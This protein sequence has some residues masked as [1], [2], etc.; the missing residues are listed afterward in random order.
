[1]HVDS[2]ML[3]RSKFFLIFFSFFILA[4]AQG[5]QC[6][7]QGSLAD[8]FSDPPREYRPRV[9]WHWMNGNITREGVRKDIEWMDRAGVV[10][11]HCF[12]A[13]FDVPR[14]VE[15]RLPYMTPE[16]KD[17][18][19]YA[20]DLADSLDMEVSIAS[21][22][23]WSLTGGPWVSKEDAMKKLVWSET[24]VQGGK[25]LKL[26]LEEPSPIC[27]PYLNC[28]RYR[29]DPH[30]YDFYRDVAVV[31]VRLA[32]GDLSMDEM[33]ARL[34]TSD[35]TAP[36]DLTDGIYDNTH[37]VG[38]GPEGFAWVLVEFDRPR[39]VRAY[40]A[41]V[42]AVD[43][44]NYARRLE[45]SDD[46]VHFR[47]VIPRAPETKTTVN[48]YDIPPTT[49]KYFRFCSN[50]P[51]K[52]LNYSELALYGV[53]KVNCATE[54]AGFFTS[55][56]TRDFY[57]T[58][59]TPDAAPDVIDLTSRVSQGVLDWKAPSGRWRI[60]RFGYS[61]TGKQNG[62]ASP[63][64]TGLEVDKY[65][66]DAVARY[67]RQYFKLYDDASG[68]RL[69]SLISHLMIDSY[70][71]QCQTWT[72]SMPEQFEARRGYSLIPWLPAVAGEVLGSAARTERFLYDWRRTMEEMM[73]EGH[74]DSVDPILAEY[75][76]KRHTEAQEYSRVYTADGMDVRRHADIPMA[77]FW[78]REPYASYECEEADMREAASVAH[79][80][81]QN[82]CASE[83][84]TTNGN[85]F[86]CYDRQ[87]AW[88]M[89]PGLL[90]PAADA[91][92]ASGLTRFIIHS[93]I[94]Q[95][96]DDKVPGLT[97]N[98]FGMAFN[99]HN[100]WASEARPW[101]DYLSRST[102]LLSQGRFA[103]DVAYY[104][105]ETTNAVA[106]FHDE[107]PPVPFG[108]AYDF[109]NKTLVTD[110]L[111][112]EGPY[113][114]TESGMAYR[115]VIIDRECKYMSVPV[116]RKFAEFARAGVLLVGDEPLSH[117]DLLG[118]D[119]EFRSLVD[120]I[121][122]SGRFNVVR[123]SQLENALVSMRIPRDVDFSNPTGADIR[124][125]HRHLESGELY[126]IANLNP[127]YRRLEISF[128][129]SGMKPVILHAETGRVEPAR[130][131]MEGGRTK[132]MLDLVPDDAQFVL[133]EEKTDVKEFVLPRSRQLAGTEVKGP[134]RISFQQGRGAP[135][136]LED[137]CPGLLSESS[138]PG[139]RFFSGTATYSCSFDFSR[140]DG[141]ASYVLDL[142]EV[143]DMARVF[144]NGRDL[145]L[146][147]KTPFRI[148][149]TDA[150]REGRNELELK[151][152]NTWHNRVIGDL[153]PDVRQK[154][155]YT[156]Y[157][158][159]DA[160]SP[161]RES[162]LVGPV[163]VYPMSK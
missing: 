105:S 35:G 63:E 102:Y 114:V 96:V 117:C 83:S 65:D 136:C 152:T 120:D 141:N 43:R 153:Q 128:N 31:A 109:I 88:A 34:S 82:I 107:R 48:V 115:V 28:S 86:D 60:Y 160:D 33:G 139:V 132:V 161:L 14:I 145:G 112:T 97:L 44:Y 125:V 163:A 64:A 11:Y 79:I 90:K 6:R 32:P 143:H 130:Y 27:G 144:L 9:W 100:T 123:P 40:L 70:E 36:D 119:A 98:N 46:G 25:R 91:A 150:L 42:D 137:A 89:H 78:M 57:P 131:R 24:V 148:D 101:T 50:D 1:M 104:Y 13:G 39:T 54:K 20:L 92:M 41:A 118:S 140:T 47:T 94:H 108:H 158:F 38:R 87:L 3:H 22:P 10:G 74:Y 75:G 155:T 159:Y 62:P 5:V 157:K 80:Y 55:P 81:G 73:A 99:R 113:V 103:A 56:S 85:D 124:F 59:G 154:V 23:G 29:N 66:A 12:D 37:T 76:M 162:G 149:V 129:V 58:P 138:D 116:L 126:W 69:G 18:F 53:T 147:W 67:Y 95:P 17:V 52:P 84:F 156:A 93:C 7:A 151:V 2:D 77:S 122:H 15:K 8:S 21:S 111:R 19:N 61:L 135:E 134:W 68:G 142:G 110:V 4:A 45:C 72:A 127:E 30:R 133:F 106:R 121:W 49:A 16:W 71:S 26:S 51:A 146:L